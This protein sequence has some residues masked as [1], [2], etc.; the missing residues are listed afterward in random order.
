MLD[1]YSIHTR[2]SQTLYPS[3]NEDWHHDMCFLMARESS[4][5]PLRAA[6]PERRWPREPR[7][8]WRGCGMVELTCAAAARVRHRA[9][10]RRLILHP[11]GPC[12]PPHAGAGVQGRVVTCGCGGGWINRGQ[13]AGWGRAALQS[14]GSAR[15]AAEDGKRRRGGKDFVFTK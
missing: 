10:L 8:S 9:H 7:R 1:V 2:T 15:D 5:P 13:S 12:L 14:H 6:G 4:K 3:S 11:L